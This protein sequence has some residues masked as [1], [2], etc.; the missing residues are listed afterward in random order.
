MRELL[1]TQ[2]TQASKIFVHDFEQS[3]RIRTGE[4]G[5]EAL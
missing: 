2:I 4:F 3:I 5:A 1:T